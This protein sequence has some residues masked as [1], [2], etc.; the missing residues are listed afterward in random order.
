[1]AFSRASIKYKPIKIGFL[2]RD[3]SIEDLVKSA[4]IN[5]LLWGGI[6]NPIIPIGNGDNTF[7]DQLVKLFSVDVLYAVSETAEI[8]DFLKKYT[9]L[10]DP[11]H[12]AEKIF[13]EDNWKSKKKSVG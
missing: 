6:Y 2:V 9:F 12:Y 11:G 8:Q 10:K 4:G 1:M 7:A 3:D 5:S 13:Y